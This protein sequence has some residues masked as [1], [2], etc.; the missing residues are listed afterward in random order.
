MCDEIFGR[1]NFIGNLIVQI[2]PSGRTNDAFFATSH[3]YTLFYAKNKNNV[4]I[5]FLPLSDEQKKQ[6][7]QGDGEDT[8]KWRDFLRTG[9]YS[10]PEERPNSYYPIYFNPF[11]KTI[12]IEKVSDNDIE[13]LPL[14][15]NNK[16]RVWR[17]TKKSLLEHLENDE[18]KIV[19]RGNT[20]KVQIIDKIKSGIRP[21][22][23]WVDS[24]YDAASHGTKLLKNLFDG[25]KLFSFP[26]SLYAVED[27]ISL[28]TSEEDD[29]I[30]DFFGGSG[31]TAHAV[32]ELNKEDGGNRQFVL[33][34]QM[35]YI[36]TVTA[37]RVQKVIENNQGGSFVY[38][39][40]AND[41]QNFRNEVK[42]A[43]ANE[44]NAL[45]EKAKN[46]S[47]LSARIDRNKFNGFEDLSEAEKRELLCELVDA[48][49]LY[50]NY[51]DMESAD[52][53]ISEA[54]KAL[55]KQFYG[56]ER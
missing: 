45:F 39:E 6:Y 34:E 28:F 49:T 17:K 47:F 41:A 26:K 29:L 35:D 24:R 10:T 38:C 43:P 54:D 21:K 2:K 13:I 40:L 8:Y 25:E 15:S 3:E 18:I 12:T 1:D 53:Q 30:L 55:N 20:Y 22:T 27:I 31:T 5:N 7:N 42:T 46:S 23:I 14:D 56:E 37:K 48:N 50:V 51:A 44:L 33:V 32:L 9:G 11:S 36:E 19:K 52:Y 16:K 4:S